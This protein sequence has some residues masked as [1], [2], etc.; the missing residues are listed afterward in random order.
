MKAGS[1]ALPQALAWMPSPSHRQA[2]VFCIKI[3]YVNRQCVP[4]F[5]KTVQ[6]KG[7]TPVI[8][9]AKRLKQE[10]CHVFQGGLSHMTS[11]S[12][13]GLQSEP[14]FKKKKNLNVE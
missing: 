10:D 12:Q 14:Y 3:S 11:S 13:H 6:A 2:A 4:L 5:H 8:V 7:L 1:G 9:A